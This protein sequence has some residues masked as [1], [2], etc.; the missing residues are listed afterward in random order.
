MLIIHKYLSKTIIHTTGLVVLLLVGLEA[1]IE[2]TRE[3]HDMGTGYYG[4]MQ[5]LA[6]VPMILPT[7]VCELFPM[8]G[9]LGCIMGL[10]M[11]ASHSELVVLRASGI[12]ISNIAKVVL[13]CAAFLAVIM[14]VV[15]EFIAP[16]LQEKANTYKTEALGGGQTLVTTNGIWIHNNNNFIHIKKISP[17]DKIES[18]TRYAFNGDNKLLLASFAESGEYKNGQW[19]FHNVTQTNFQDNTTTTQTLSEQQWGF[20]LNPKLL[21]VTSV[22]TDQKTLL[23]LHTFIKYLK[24]SGLNYTQYEFI[25]WQRILQPFATLVMIM[26]AIPFVF[27]PL[28]NATMGLRMLTGITLG[29]S[30]RILNQ[31]VGPLCMVYQIK[32]FIA[33]I[34]PTII[35]FVF[36]VALIHIATIR[37]QA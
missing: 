6:Y 20:A 29:F 3:F 34:M 11:L 22:D 23:E 12:S 18:V 28:R 37:K 33:A 4:L 27:G 15:S 10:G 36:G 31:F 13:K 21:G 35:F 1:F 8:A 19:I 17:N 26:L 14:F 7:N 16:M 2:F 9:L 5:V 32:P 24:Q 30:F 25:F